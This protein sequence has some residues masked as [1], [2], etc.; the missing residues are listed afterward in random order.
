[1]EIRTYK[2]EQYEGCP[3]VIRRIGLDNWEYITYIRGHIYAQHTE[4]TPTKLGYFMKFFGTW[5]DVYTKK[6][7]QSNIYVMIAMAE[8]T[9]ETVCGIDKKPKKAIHITKN[10]VEKLKNKE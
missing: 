4:I 5:K 10:D 8:T 3:I 1:M 7:L 6:Q 9:I 2:T